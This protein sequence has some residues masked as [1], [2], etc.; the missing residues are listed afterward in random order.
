V[1]R[2]IRGDLPDGVYHVTAR[3]VN[4]CAV[5]A[6][7][8]DRIVF[9]R[10]LA[11]SMERF[12]WRC[13]ALCLMGTH[14]HLLVETIR[15]RLS[16]GL[17]RLNGVYA[18][19]FN[20]RHERT[21]HLFGDRFHAWLLH[22]EDHLGATTAYILNNPVRAGLVDTAT[23]WPWSLPASTQSEQVFVRAQGYT[24]SEWP[25]TSS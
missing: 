1:P 11:E 15:A 5:F 23:D 25:P 8:V 10:L 14:Y 20:R 16:A 13:H 12:A 18:Q 22:D 9:L 2:S 17:H 7:D 19:R 4:R 21:G 3:G 6:D 24:G